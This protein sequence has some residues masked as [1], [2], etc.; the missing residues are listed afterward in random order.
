[1]VSP[2]ADLKLWEKIEKNPITR[3]YLL[4]QD[5]REAVQHLQ[6]NPQDL[7]YVW[8]TTYFFNFFWDHKSVRNVDIEFKWQ[9]LQKG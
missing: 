9:I 4:Q 8:Y 6:K 3:Q 1:M 7:A 5:Y 2:F